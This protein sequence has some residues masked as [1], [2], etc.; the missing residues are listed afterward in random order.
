VVIDF[1]ESIKLSYFFKEK[2]HFDCNQIK[3]LVSILDIQVINP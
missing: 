2:L 1:E 3:I